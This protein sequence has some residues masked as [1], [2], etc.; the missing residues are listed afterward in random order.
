MTSSSQL[1]RKYQPGAAICGLVSASR[2]LPGGGLA[3]VFARSENHFVNAAL[4]GL[5]AALIGER[6]QATSSGAPPAKLSSWESGWTMQVGTDQVTSTTFSTAALTAPVGGAPNVLS[7]SGVQNPSSGL[8][9]VVLTAIWNPGPISGSTIGECG[10]LL[11]P[12]TEFSV[13]WVRTASNTAF[14]Y[15][16]T[17]S[18]RISVADGDFVPVPI[19]AF[20]GLRLDWELQVTFA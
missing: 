18:S 6:L 15:P 1:D 20:E 16:Q 13:G 4:K 3:P 11:R 5:V 9:R 12:F 17:L 14:S 19:S 8:F 10:L 7:A 2:V